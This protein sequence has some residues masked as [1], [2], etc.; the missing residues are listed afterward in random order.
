[1]KAEILV[2]LFAIRPMQGDNVYTYTDRIRKLYVAAQQTDVDQS[3]ILVIVRSLPDAGREKVST[4]Y[5][6]YK[7]LKSLEQLL[8]FM[9][10][11]VT[12]L[13]GSRSDPC[14]WFSEMLSK[15]SITASSTNNTLAYQGSGYQRSN[16]LGRNRNNRSHSKEHRA[17]SAPYQKGA[18]PRKEVKFDT[19]TRVPCTDP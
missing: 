5:P 7:G 1:M 10:K 16:N 18:T 4:Q 15:T 8:E 3:L 6:L 12:M 14:D 9:C 13:T 19:Q 11:N 2:Q 17:T